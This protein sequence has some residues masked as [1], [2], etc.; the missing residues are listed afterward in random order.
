MAIQEENQQNTPAKTENVYDKDYR[1]Q[2]NG[3]YPDPSAKRNVGLGGETERRGQKDKLENLHIGGNEVSGYGANDPNEVESIA[4]GPGFEFEG[5][6][7][8]G[9]GTVNG[10]R[11]ADQP[12]GSDETEPNENASGYNR[13]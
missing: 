10:V 2:T 12:F 6:Y 5:S 9:D 4:Q 11:S 13:I 8:E 1:Q 3:N 7:E